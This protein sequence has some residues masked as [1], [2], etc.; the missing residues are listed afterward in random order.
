MLR[1]T[2]KARQLYAQ[3]PVDG[4]QGSARR[5]FLISSARSAGDKSNVNLVGRNS[6]TDP[7]SA[8]G[9]SET[10]IKQMTD[11]NSS[12]ISPLSYFILSPIT[13]LHGTADNL[14]D[15][16]DKQAAWATWAALHRS[17]HARHSKL[18]ARMTL[19]GYALRRVWRVGRKM[20][21]YYWLPGKG[22]RLNLRINLGVVPK[23]ARSPNRSPVWSHR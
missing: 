21:R 5:K 20:V 2:D 9:S 11:S 13:P 16:H 3:C 18:K 15:P 7:Q 6:S 17:R 14:H 4:S 12:W 23:E 22:F 19:P 10:P 8:L 1:R